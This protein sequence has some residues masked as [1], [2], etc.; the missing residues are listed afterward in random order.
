[1]QNVDTNRGADG[2]GKSHANSGS[3]QLGKTPGCDETG[4]ETCRILESPQPGPKSCREWRCEQKKIQIGVHTLRLVMCNFL[5]NKAY[6]VLQ[7]CEQ[8]KSVRAP[9]WLARRKACISLGVRTENDIVHPKSTLPGS[10]RQGDAASSPIA[11]SVQF[12]GARRRENNIQGK[13]SVGGIEK[14]P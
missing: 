5:E 11:G 9:S 4:V 6:E 1:M 7:E 12:G 10:S 13:Q 2:R 8:S 14:T 3:G